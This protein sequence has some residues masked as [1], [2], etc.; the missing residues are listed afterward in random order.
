LIV[1]GFCMQSWLFIGMECFLTWS[2]SYSLNAR[3]IPI[4]LQNEGWIILSTY[5]NSLNFYFNYK[6]FYM[7]DIHVLLLNL[8]TICWVRCWASPFTQPYRTTQLHIFIILVYLSH[9]MGMT[10][11]KVRVKL[12][13]SY[14]L[15]CLWKKKRHLIY[16]EVVITM[17]QS[18]SC[19]QHMKVRSSYT[20]K[21]ELVIAFTYFYALEEIWGFVTY[22]FCD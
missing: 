2:C 7:F 20:I 22:L 9:F 19:L 17:S 16:V 12:T 4:Y 10:P 21:L 1:S 3:C 8:I 5:L 15:R 14:G 6:S 18:I 11:T 13:R